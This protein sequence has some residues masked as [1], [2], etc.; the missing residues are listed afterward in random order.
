MNQA[1]NVFGTLEKYGSH[2]PENYLTEAFVYL[3][4]LLLSREPAAG[5]DMINWLCGLGV[6][7]RLIAANEIVIKT[8]VDIKPYG[9]VDIAIQSGKNALFYIEVKLDSALDGDQLWTYRED[10]QQHHKGQRTGMVFLSRSR[11]AAIPTK[12]LDHE[13]HHIC[14]YEVYDRIQ[15]LDARDEVAA[16]FVTNFQRFLEAKYMSY[17]QISGEYSDGITAMN[18]LTHMLRA[19][20]SEAFPKAKIKVSGGFGWRGYGVAPCYFC[21]IR[22]EAPHLLVCEY[23]PKNGVPFKRN[24]NLANENFFALSKNEQFEQ[25]VQFLRETYTM[26]LKSNP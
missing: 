14:W 4:D 18:N 25:I 10:L 9:I 26:S 1:R 6:A 2:A 16:F 19:A 12:L 15:G 17:S 13:Y 8:Q 5:L 22:F 20:I 11:Q 7:E 21:G 23:Y 24:L 3:L